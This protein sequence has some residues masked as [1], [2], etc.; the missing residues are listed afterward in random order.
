MSPKQIISEVLPININDNKCIHQVWSELIN[1]FPENSQ[2]P[3]S[4]GISSP[5]EDC[6]SAKAAKK[7]SNFDNSPN[8]STN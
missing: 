8:T 3:P 4:S 7:L 1:S 6:N 5:P 2:K